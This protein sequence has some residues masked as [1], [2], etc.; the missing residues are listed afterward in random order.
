MS[1]GFLLRKEAGCLGI[2]FLKPRVGRGGGGAE[3]VGQRGW[4]AC[5]ICRL[6]RAC[7]V[8]AGEANLPCPVVLRPALIRL[9]KTLV[10]GTQGEEPVGGGDWLPDCWRDWWAGWTGLPEAG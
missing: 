1:T 10:G 5:T 9:R 3:T 4:A 6:G 8:A 2:M 7:R